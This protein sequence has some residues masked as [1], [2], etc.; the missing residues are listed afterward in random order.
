MNIKKII[1]GG[2]MVSIVSAVSV[3][4]FAAPFALGAV[5]P[6]LSLSSVSGDTVQI[7]V[8]AD[9]NA[10]VM[11]YY[12]VASSAGM[13]SM[14]LGTT[15]SSGYFSTTLSASTYGIEAGYSVY[16]I[17]DGAQSSMQTWPVPTGTPTLNQSSVTLGLGQSVSVY[18]TGSSAP[19]YMAQNSSPNTASVQANGTQINNRYRRTDRQHNGLHLLFRH[20]VELHQPLHHRTDG[21]RDFVQ[22]KQRYRFHRW[23][24][25]DRRIRRKRQLFHN[26]Q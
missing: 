10:S 8:T 5:T 22:S 25:D 9:P 14:T 6:S 12:N 21:E 24:Y 16:A 17:V 18:S 15:N 7:S 26:Q 19:V 1:S 23:K 13:H 11:F 20:R 4:G 3:L 2:L